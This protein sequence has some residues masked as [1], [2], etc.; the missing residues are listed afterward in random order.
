MPAEPKYGL[1]AH[2]AMAGALRI[3]WFAKRGWG[4]PKTD[5]WP[6]FLD[7]DSPHPSFRRAAKGSERAGEFI[8]PDRVVAPIRIDCPSRRCR[9]EWPAERMYQDGPGKDF[10][11][12]AHEARPRLF[13]SLSSP[14]GYSHGSATLACYRKGTIQAK[15]CESVAGPGRAAGPTGS[16]KT[17]FA[18]RRIGRAFSSVFAEAPLGLKSISFEA[19]NALSAATATGQWAQPDC[20]GLDVAAALFFPLFLLGGVAIF[21]SEGA[22]AATFGFSFFGFL[23]SRLL[24]T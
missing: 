10:R 13:I 5:P 17:V 6:R 4:H 23:A 22:D 16:A 11:Q 2:T 8:G 7:S 24:R 21:V 9:E 20:Y 3:G 1:P 18:L 19:E 15:R 12:I 14:R